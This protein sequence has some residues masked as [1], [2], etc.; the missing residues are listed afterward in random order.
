MKKISVIIPVYNEEKIV[1]ELLSRLARSTEKLSYNF[2]FML[3]D[4]GSTDGTKRII[5]N[6]EKIC[7]LILLWL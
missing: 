1:A 7:H 5:E 3:I 6:M 2:E 4:D